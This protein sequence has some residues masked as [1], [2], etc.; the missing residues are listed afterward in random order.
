M[1]HEKISKKSK[2]Q[3]LYTTLDRMDDSELIANK[4]EIK[5]EE[6]YRKNEQYNFIK[7]KS[8]ECNK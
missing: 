6:V 3:D 1:H 5:Y 7:V 4:D 8:F 2:A